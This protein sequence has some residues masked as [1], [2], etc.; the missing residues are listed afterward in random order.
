MTNP[1]EAMAEAVR[2]WSD[3]ELKELWRLSGGTFYSGNRDMAAMPEHKLL[4]LLKKLVQGQPVFAQLPEVK[5]D[6]VEAEERTSAPVRPPTESETEDVL[7]AL[8]DA[9]VPGLSTGDLLQD[10][11][12]AAGAMEVTAPAGFFRVENQGDAEHSKNR[13]V[14]VETMDQHSD[15]V[16]PLFR[17]ARRLKEADVEAAAPTGAKKRGGAKS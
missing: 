10:A 13:Y 7:R 9:I 12:T 15:D 2:E 14:H 5:A 17:R 4:Q 16:F 6:D 11:G 8:I 1:I 3:Q